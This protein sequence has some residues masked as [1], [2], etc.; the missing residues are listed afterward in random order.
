[1]SSSPTWRALARSPA[2][3]LTSATPWRALGY[4]AS[5]ALVGLASLVVL[6]GVLL[7]GLLLSVLGVGLVLLAGSV[8]L[9]IPLAALERRRLRLLEGPHTDRPASPHEA[10]ARPGL[11]PW[12]TTRLREPATWREFSYALVFAV[13]LSFVNLALLTLTGLLVALV[14]AP[15]QVAV[16][17]AQPEALVLTGLG[18]AG[19]P[20]TAYVLGAAAAA[21]SWFVRLMLAPKEGEQPDR[22]MEL[23]RSRARMA[24]AF[25]A[26]RRR[27][28]R[29]LHDGAQQH[30]VALVMTL[31]L[32]E[33]ELGAADPAA[34]KGGE[35]VSRARREAKHALDELRDLIR[36]IHPQVLTDHGIAAAVSEVA[37][38]CRV[39][40]AVDV[41]LAG[42]LPAQ[43]EA[44]AYFFVSEALTNV[45][46]HSGAA[47]AT[48]H[49][50]L[51]GG[52]LSV[53]VTDDGTGG[54]ELRDGG[55]LQ[56]L[57]DR[58]AVVDGRLK[59][60]S[61]LGG[62]TALSLEIPCRHR[63]SVSS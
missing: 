59:L 17:S 14:V 37:V 55:G 42:R 22:I 11:W 58:V 30:L 2:N 29:D 7:C 39:P 12:L 57:A 24:D 10:V 27:I 15:V 9:G 49:A 36:G 52:R 46:K 51:A 50:R 54:A 16:A 34:G 28:E 60:S 23:T 47:T 45:V 38:R 32:A 40:V 18:I 44:T 53:T 48:V 41:E 63:H 3:F 8:L 19:L 13:P 21:Q 20:V 35:L 1:M 31:G 33:L 62:P 4:L 5:S 26:E 56:G 6:G 25:E 61:P 43:V